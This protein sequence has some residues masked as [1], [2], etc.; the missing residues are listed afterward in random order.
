P[1]PRR[2]PEQK[3]SHDTPVHAA[4]SRP[5]SDRWVILWIRRPYKGSGCLQPRCRAAKYGI[6][7]IASEG[8]KVSCYPTWRA[9]PSG[10]GLICKHASAKSFLRQARYRRL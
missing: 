6:A 3:A 9:D 8:L 10:G 1:N 4:S 5:Y 2:E 7:E